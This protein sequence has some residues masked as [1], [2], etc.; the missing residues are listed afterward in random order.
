MHGEVLTTIVLKEK[1]L[2]CT[3]IYEYGVKKEKNNYKPPGAKEAKE[4][5]RKYIDLHMI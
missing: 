2:T 3:N 4:V 1:D 5:M